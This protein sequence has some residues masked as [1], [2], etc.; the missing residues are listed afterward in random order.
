[1]TEPCRLA[2]VFAISFHTALPSLRCLLLRFIFFSSLLFSLCDILFSPSQF[3]VL[4][5]LCTL[6]SYLYAEKN[7][8]H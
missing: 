2:A 3:E 8:F 6:F 4:A 1:M 7:Y 5:A